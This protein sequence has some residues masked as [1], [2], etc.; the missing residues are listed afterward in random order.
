MTIFTQHTDAKAEADLALD[1]DRDG[2]HFHRHIY[3]SGEE[4]MITVAEVK[5]LR[6]VE[7]V[8]RE[9]AE[10]IRVEVEFWDNPSRLL[11]GAVARARAWG[12]L[13]KKS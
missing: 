8:A 9:L 7:V 10:A 13:S 5:R 6:A 2:E 1:D 4:I 3:V 11:L 12:L